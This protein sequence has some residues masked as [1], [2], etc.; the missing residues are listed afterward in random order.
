MRVI[1]SY[2]SLKDL[3]SIYEYIA[4]DSRI[5]A[6]R[7]VDKIIRRGD[8]ISCFPN[9]GR[10][11]PEMNRPD[12]REIIEGSYRVIYHVKENETEILTVFHGA[13]LFPEHLF[14]V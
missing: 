11:V 2:E 12:I 1:W 14:E 9:S 4:R 7:T 3:D 6:Q 8:Q 13:R 5:Y 10:K